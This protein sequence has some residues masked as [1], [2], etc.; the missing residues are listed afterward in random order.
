MTDEPLSLPAQ[1]RLM[2]RIVEQ[3]GQLD[4]A[5]RCWLMQRL[6]AEECAD[7]VRALYPAMDLPSPRPP[8]PGGGERI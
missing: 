6:V 8:E 2:K 7:V 1:L 5:G 4:Y 3:V